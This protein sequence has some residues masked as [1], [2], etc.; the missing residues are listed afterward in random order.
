MNNSQKK[1]IK[2]GSQTAKAGFRNEHTVADKFNNWEKDNEAQDWLN[3][4]GYELSQIDSV[5]AGRI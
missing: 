1:K 5:Y 3:V 2:L 4:M